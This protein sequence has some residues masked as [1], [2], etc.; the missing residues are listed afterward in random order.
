MSTSLP[1]A[2]TFVV[3]TTADIVDDTDGVTSLREAVLLANADPDHSLITFDAGLQVNNANIDFDLDGMEL[4]LDSAITIDAD[5]ND[6]GDGDVVIAANEL[7]RIFFLSSNSDVVLDG[8]SLSEGSVDGD[9]S[10]LTSNSGGA[11]FVDSFASLSVT[12]SSIAFSNAS[13]LGG[14]I[15]ISGNANVVLN[16]LLMFFNEASAGGA[17]SSFGSSLVIEDSVFN[18]LNRA[19]EG[20]ALYLGAGD[21]TIVDTE[22]S[23][24]SADF[25]GGGIYNLSSGAVTLEGVTIQSN[26]ALTDSGGGIYNSGDGALGGVAILNSSLVANNAPFGGG[27][28][29]TGDLEIESSLL[30][31]NTATSLG[32]GLHNGADGV[33]TLTNVTV[34]ANSA[35]GQGGGIYNSIA[36]GSTSIDL[37]NTTVTG[38]TGSS[39]GGV[40]NSATMTAVNS[41]FSGNTGGDL[42]GGVTQ[43]DNVIGGDPALI[44][45]ALAANGGGELGDNGGPTQTVLLR[46]DPSNPALDIGQPQAGVPLDAVGAQRDIDLPNVDNGG[47]VDAGAVE[48]GAQPQEPGSLVVTIAGDIMDAFDGQTSLREAID[49]ANSQAGLDEIIFSDDFDGG[50]EDLIRLTL[51]ELNITDAVTINGGASG[52]TITG[53]AA[54]D[55]IT[56]A[57][58]DL[59]DA[60]ATYDNNVFQD[61][62]RVFLIDAD[63]TL[64]G[65]TI[66]GGV[67]A[68]DPV[69]GT[70]FSAERGG[71][72]HFRSGDLTINNS[73]VVGNIAAPQEFFEGQGGGIY[74]A[75]SSLLRVVDSTVRDNLVDGLDG[76]GVSTGSG[77]QD[78]GGG[79]GIW[80]DGTVELFG[81]AISGNLARVRAGEGEG[82]GVY[83]FTV[84]ADDTDFIENTLFATTLGGG[85]VVRGG[86]GMR[87]LEAF[88][89]N[90]RF[91]DNADLNP[92]GGS[93]FT[94]GGG[95]FLAIA[96]FLKDSEV[97]GNFSAG[98]GGGIRVRD[99]SVDGFL[100]ENSTIANNTS[101][102]EGGGIESDVLNVANSTI[103]GNV[104]GQG[105]GGIDGFDLT[106]TDSLVLGNSGSEGEIIDRSGQAMLTGGNIV[107]DELSFDGAF[108]ETVSAADVF[109]ATSEVLDLGGNG[110]GVQAGVLA[111]NGGPSQTVLIKLGGPAQ[112]TGQAIPATT[113]DQRGEARPFGEAGDLGA[114]ELQV[115]ANVDP[116]LVSIDAP[117]AT[118]TTDASPTEATG[119]VVFEDADLGDTH[120]VTLAFESVS[121]GEGPELTDAQVAA[122]LS[123]GSV[124][125][126]PGGSERS[127]ELSFAAASL[128]F[129]YLS[130][131]EPVT[132]SY[133]LTIDD[134]EGGVVSAPAEVV[135]TGT[136]DAPVAADDVAAIDTGGQA[137]IT[138][139]ANDTDVD[140]DSLS[141]L[142]ASNGAAGITSVNP[143]GTITYTAAPGFEGTDSFTYEISDGNGGTDTAT[144]T[145]TGD[146]AAPVANSHIEFDSAKL[147]LEAGGKPNLVQVALHAGALNGIGDLE[148]SSSG[149]RRVNDDVFGGVDEGGTLIAS[150]LYVRR[151]GGRFK[152]DSLAPGDLKDGVQDIGGWKTLEGEKL[153]PLLGDILSIDAFKMRR[154]ADEVPDTFVFAG[155]D[156]S[157]F[158]PTSG[159]IVLKGGQGLRAQSKNFGLEFGIDRNGAGKPNFAGDGGPTKEIAGPEV[160]LFTLEDGLLGTGVSFGVDRAPGG[161]AEV[162]LDF[163]NLDRVTGEYTQVGA[164]SIIELD[165]GRP[166]GPS[167]ALANLDFTFDAVA[168]SSADGDRFR[169][170]MLE[171]NTFYDGL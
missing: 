150:E 35:T 143:D 55:D 156:A 82:G 12:N 4:F 7:S 50:A 132:L 18:G 5:I 13:S 93:N 163:Y 97:S 30:A 74:A 28:F 49:F 154:D 147:A 59:T 68:F 123:V 56:G 161:Q 36:G 151:G 140:G 157:G 104:A 106:L 3:T 38:N 129:D 103:T 16:D 166:T 137:V 43:T 11:I 130:D 61:N 114:V 138:V 141:V 48:L 81:S 65:L 109:D 51:G 58:T 124:T 121:N 146:P 60:Q 87:A 2:N 126:A 95:G 152:D 159:Q 46:D 33:A 22:I 45:A 67:A 149:T 110:T 41:I 111:D 14:G 29:N 76:N 108:V 84:I 79:G 47:T 102:L 120:T 131:G 78:G 105:A 54:D 39:G 66:T 86:G 170:E 63:T 162:A 89:T 32:G 119:L 26:S 148:Y 25:A 142:S 165:D 15:F 144:V 77:L 99:I 53:D 64:N 94:S 92:L 57:G 88:I 80:A 44:F 17:I 85:S 135:V 24:N 133:T 42:S 117:M 136:N 20:G 169:L 34:A 62:S 40:Q 83:G 167:N 100:I 134:G 52:V 72:I 153:N 125:Q 122:L 158:D 107:G 21:V 171:I 160:L 91:I 112:D 23:S 8:L 168:F 27:V 19:E 75:R 127:V 69:S 6:D 70:L 98:F 90:S 164:D 101:L 9:P 145:V 71:G 139:L 116:T 31:S 10:D 1:P 113:T 96:G 73:D 118:E 128:V 155:D 115:S 37:I